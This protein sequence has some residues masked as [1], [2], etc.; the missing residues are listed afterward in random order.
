MGPELDETGT[1]VK[2]P[3]RCDWITGSVFLTPPG[4]WHSHH[5]E[6]DEKA[7][8]LPMQ[9]AGLF[10]YQRTLDIRFAPAMAEATPVQPEEAAT[11]A[12]AAGKAT[13]ALNTDGAV[14]EPAE[15]ETC[16]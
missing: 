11:E 10:T 7:W 13:A 2:D 15:L 8:V 3:I 1:R 9:D 16:G 4:W 5:N 6:S 14:A 12:G